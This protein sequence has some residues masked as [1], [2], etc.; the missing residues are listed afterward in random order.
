MST[1]FYSDEAKDVC[2][3]HN[4]P[5]FRSELGNSAWCG[6]CQFEGRP[7][8]VYR[9]SDR[10]RSPGTHKPPPKVGRGESMGSI[11]G[12]AFLGVPL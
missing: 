4:K 5:L 10:N 6:D 9:L 1:V 2:S 12:K 7:F 3:W 11:M 8:T